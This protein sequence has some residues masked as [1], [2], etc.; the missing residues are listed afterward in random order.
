M[1]LP[2]GYHIHQLWSK[3]T[4]RP[5]PS[6]TKLT[7]HL[8]HVAWRVHAHTVCSFLL[9][10]AVG[11]RHLY[12]C[13][14][15]PTVFCLQGQA[16]RDAATWAYKA[17][18]DPPGH[19]IRGTV[20]CQ[21][22]KNFD[23]HLPALEVSEQMMWLEIIR[24]KTNDS[25]VWS[26]KTL[27][28]LHICPWEMEA[29]RLFPATRVTWQEFATFWTWNVDHWNEKIDS[30]LLPSHFQEVVPQIPLTM[31]IQNQKTLNTCML[32]WNECLCQTHTRT[33]SIEIYV[34]FLHQPL[35]SKWSLYGPVRAQGLLSD[36]FRRHTHK[37]TQLD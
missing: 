26:C 15:S 1:S 6:T 16:A 4:E 31:V 32:L 24:Q 3:Q 20:G 25:K 8:N 36:A 28:T 23:P 27:S 13:S 21:T 5:K 2:N 7:L 37:H 14:A 22:S 11:T 33:S 19:W 29:P 34:F 35:Q 17:K 18:T 30:S 12:T 9:Q 10:L